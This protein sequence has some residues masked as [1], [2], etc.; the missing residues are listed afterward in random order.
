VLELIEG[1]DGTRSRYGSRILHCYL[2]HKVDVK[3]SAVLRPNDSSNKE[4]QTWKYER[5]SRAAKDITAAMKANGHIHN[6][7]TE[8]Q[9]T[10]ATYITL[11]PEVRGLIWQSTG[12][13][14][15]SLVWRNQI[16]DCEV[17]QLQRLPK[18][19]RSQV[20]T[21]HSLQN[22]QWRGGQQQILKQ[23]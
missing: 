14:S 23:M 18:L 7:L 12:L 3:S 9:S 22:Q 19:T 5:V 11:P 15:E 16:F 6:D 8:Y 2:R 1:R 21:S 4:S 13:G 17:L 20:T 10:D